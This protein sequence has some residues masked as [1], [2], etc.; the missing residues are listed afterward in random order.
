MDT[1]FAG[2]ALQGVITDPKISFPQKNKQVLFVNKRLIQ[3]PMISKAISD[4][5]K[6]YIPHGNHPGYIL[7]LTLDPTQVDV[8]VHPRKMEVRFAQESTLFRAVYHA[9]EDTLKSVSL[10]AESSNTASYSVPVS[11]DISPSISSVKEPQYYTGS[12][13]KFKSYSPYTP[14]EAHPAQ[15]ALQFSQAVLTPR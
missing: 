11:R 14:R 4:A 8:N 1:S 7:F 3:S 2:I 5:Y 10:V 12:G 6:R 15:A 9:L 13:T